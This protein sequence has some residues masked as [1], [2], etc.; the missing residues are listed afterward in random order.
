MIWKFQWAQ[1][2][3]PNAWKMAQSMPLLLKHGFL[4]SDDFF[5]IWYIYALVLNKCFVLFS[6]TLKHLISALFCFNNSEA[7]NKCCFVFNN[8]RALDK[9]FVLFLTTLSIFSLVGEPSTW[10]E[11]VCRSIEN[12]WSWCQRDKS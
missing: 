11:V 9:C 5:S 7:L 4:A 12:Q 3:H 6:T 1:N 2:I 8:S 10:M